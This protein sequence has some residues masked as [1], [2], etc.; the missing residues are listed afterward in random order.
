M[1]AMMVAS[2]RHYQKVLPEALRH[3]HMHWTQVG[4]VHAEVLVEALDRR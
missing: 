4:S 1:A 3:W 2:G